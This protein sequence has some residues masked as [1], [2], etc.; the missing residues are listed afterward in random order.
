MSQISCE[1]AC[2]YLDVKK[3]LLDEVGMDIKTVKSQMF[4]E[5]KEISKNWDMV[6]RLEK[7]KCLVDRFTLGATVEELSLRIM[8]ALFKVDL[9]TSAVAVIVGKNVK[10]FTDLSKVASIL[11][12]S[13]E[14]PLSSPKTECHSSSSGYS[15]SK[16]FKQYN[17]LYSSQYKCFKC[18]L[19]GHRS[20]SVE[21]K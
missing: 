7:L 18:G 5:W 6:T 15:G 9:S 14:K 10:S 19:M 21:L 20:L 2:T 8:K 3:K 12:S 4:V 16:Y 1:A 17:K 13:G 11:K